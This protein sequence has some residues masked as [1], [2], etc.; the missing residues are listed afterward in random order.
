MAGCIRLGRLVGRRSIG[1]AAGQAEAAVAVAASAS[2]RRRDEDVRR[3]HYTV[4][5]GSYLSRAGGRSA[6]RVHGRP[7]QSLQ[8]QNTVARLG[9]ISPI[10]LLFETDGGQNFGLWR[11]FLDDFLHVQQLHGRDKMAAVHDAEL[12]L[13]TAS[14]F[15]QL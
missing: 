15:V 11:L 6:E 4:A 13:A 12:L 2:F 9:D 8:V 5:V 10:G 1:P 14:V 7:S 3:R